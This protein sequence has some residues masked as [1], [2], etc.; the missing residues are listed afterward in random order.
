[1]NRILTLV[2][3]VFFCITYSCN[4]IS[5][6]SSP[7]EVQIQLTEREFYNFDIRNH[8]DQPGKLLLS[9]I[10]H[11][12]RYIPLETTPACLLSRCRRAEIFNNNIYVADRKA[13]YMFDMDGSFIQQIGKI[14]NGPGEYGSVLWF[15]FIISTNEIILY[16]YPTGRINVYDAESGEYKR[17]FRLDFDPNGVV[18]F[19]PGKLAFLTWNTKQSEHPTRK[20]EIYIC[21]LEGGILDSI[22]DK[23]IPFTGN[24]A[25]PNHY[26]V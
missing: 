7:Q 11:E 8:L 18:E 12:I 10:A 19:P 16:S 26:Y 5:D 25:G 6:R 17:S 15:N 22:P 13:L 23:R 21:N 1:M 2:C 20:S 9:S 24:I 4:S 14:G 3:M